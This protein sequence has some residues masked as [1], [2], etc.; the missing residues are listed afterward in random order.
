MNGAES[1]IR[2]SV[3]ANIDVCFANP[4]TTEIPLVRALDTIPGVRGILCLFEGVCTG[5][6]DGYGRM[7]GRPAMTLLHLG[8]GFA[9][10][11]AYLHDARRA[12]SPVVNLIGEHATWHQEVDAPLHSDIES[13]ARPVSAWLRRS[14]HSSELAADLREA[15][16][17]AAVRPGRISTLIVPHDLQLGPADN[18]VGEELPFATIPEPPKVDADTIRAIAAALRGR[19]TK[20]MLLG[21]HGLRERGLRA[22]GR[23]AVSTGVRLIA[24]SF[25]ARWERGRGTPLVER[26]PYFPEMAVSVLAPSRMIV[27]AGA[28]SPVSFFGYPGIPSH[29]ISNEQQCLTLAGPEDDVEAALEALADELAAP[30]LEVR[31][32]SQPLPWRGSRGALTAESMTAVVAALVPENAIVMDEG[33]TSTGGYTAYFQSAAPHSYLTQPGGAIGLGTP[34]AV[35]AAIACPDRPVI[36][37]QADGSGMYTFQSL[38]TMARE[39]LNIKTVICNNGGY[40]ILGVEMARACPAGVDQ[41]AGQARAMMEFGSPAID[42]VSLARGLG[43]PA[44]SVATVEDLVTALERALAEP[45]PYL[46]DAVLS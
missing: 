2:A 39:S 5:A 15:V 10:G 23:I 17:V 21:A 37:L 32:A 24:E 19:E 36:T 27:L 31:S 22:A 14:R 25:P 45:G 9:N 20:A 34:C 44:V 29:Y 28:R 1:L 46:I 11:I 38:W 3:A 33:H 26:L 42:W 43:V 7:A 6:A 35:G 13:L 41:P 30:A 18:E 12:R 8:P 16:R 4:G 40:R